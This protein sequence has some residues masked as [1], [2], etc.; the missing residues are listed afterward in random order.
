MKQKSGS[1]SAPVRDPFP[2]DKI[3][4]AL[5]IAAREVREDAARRGTY[6]VIWKDGKVFHDYPKLE[7]LRTTKVAEAGA[8]ASSEG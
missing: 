4:V 8:D 7:E 5:R 1:G 2:A 3:E 6:I